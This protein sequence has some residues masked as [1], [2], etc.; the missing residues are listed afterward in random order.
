MARGRG[1]K[2]RAAAVAEASEGMEPRRVEVD[3][4]IEEIVIE[5]AAPV[6]VEAERLYDGKTRQQ[7]VS[8][9]FMLLAGYR[10]RLSR[11]T[12][13]APPA[14][15]QDQIRLQVKA[16]GIIPARDQRRLCAAAQAGSTEARELLVAC[17]QRAVYQW[18]QP[19]QGNHGLSLEDLAQEG[20]VGLAM[21]VDKYSFEYADKATFLT[22]ARWWVKQAYAR[23]IQEKGGQITLPSYMQLIKLRTE[24]AV[25]ALEARGIA[26]PSR[27]QLHDEV[28]ATSR[29]PVLPEHIDLAM[30][31]IGRRYT[32]MDADLGTDDGSVSLSSIIADPDAE[33]DVV[34]QEGWVAQVVEE[35]L[36]DL[37]PLQRTIM[38]RKFGLAG[39]QET[40]NVQ[41]MDEL[42]LRKGKIDNEIK[43]ALTKLRPRFEAAG[44]TPEI[45]FG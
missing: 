8:A 5:A 6:A 9:V 45:L 2:Q 18:A 17:N 10:E 38:V 29:K 25:R 34:A 43:L 44:L 36:G 31:H 14:T 11:F 37:T 33:Q 27:E 35:N 4:Q 19:Y 24:R 23:A 41:L 22:Y 13:E 21:A 32:S 12:A 20:N 42:G 15:I 28:Q 3:A 7:A 40:A 30:E 26:S 1:S 39:H 16:A